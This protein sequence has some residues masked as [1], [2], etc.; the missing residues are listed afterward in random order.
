MS[1]LSILHFR[2]PLV[3]ALMLPALALAGCGKKEEAKA[4]PPRPVLVATVKFQPEQPARSFVGT[5]K[6]RV[7]T[8]I[9]FR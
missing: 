5:I 7:E 8:D 3:L 6:P 4:E 9:G 2:Q 1:G